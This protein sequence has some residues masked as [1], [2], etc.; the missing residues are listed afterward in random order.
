MTDWWRAIIERIELRQQA[1]WSELV[2]VLL[3]MSYEEQVQ[4]EARFQR[5]IES[6]LTNWQQPGH[7]DALY[8]GFGPH[9]R[10]HV[11]AG[12]AC[13]RPSPEHL[14]QLV[15]GV[16]DRALELVNAT[17]GAILVV[18]LELPIYPFRAVALIDATTPP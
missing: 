14:A 5:T 9:S 4:F 8:F 11:V 3:N 1:R 17:R 15:A 13:R 16:S 18:D 7:E 10:R 2:V 6:V 12:I